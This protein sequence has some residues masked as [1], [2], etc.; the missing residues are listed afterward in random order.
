MPQYKDLTG[1]QK[2]LY[3]KL[4]TAIE[5]QEDIFSILKDVS[6]QDLQQVLTNASITQKLTNGIE[7]NLT[8]LAYAMNCNDFKERIKVILEASKDKKEVLTTASITEK[9]SNGIEYNLTPLAYAMNFND[10]EEIIKVILDV[11]QDNSVLEEV[12]VGIEEYDHTKLKKILETLK[13]QEQNEEQKTKIDGW[14]EILTKNVSSSHKS[15]KQPLAPESSIPKAEENIANNEG[16]KDTFKIESNISKRENSDK[17]PQKDTVKTINRSIMIGSVYGFIAAL[18][19]SGGCFAAG[20][21]LSI[22]AIA[23]VATFL[24]IETI[25]SGIIYLVFNPSDKLDNPDSEIAKQ[26]VVPEVC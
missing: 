14:L 4:K 15:D 9:L 16:M 11:A 18:V 5:K 2:E 19:V 13:N 17:Y 6:K 22:L 26:Q 10:F 12:F 1:K 20:V 7:Y 8:P 23:A 24:I 3:D 21:E 25:A